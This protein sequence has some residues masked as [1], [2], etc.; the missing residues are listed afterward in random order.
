MAPRRL[1]V[2]G[3]ESFTA[4]AENLRETRCGP[5]AACR[6]STAPTAFRSSGRRSTGPSAHPP[7]PTGTSMPKP[8][9]TSRN[10]TVRSAAITACS[11]AATIPAFAIVLAPMAHNGSSHENGSVEAHNNHLKV[12][13]DQALILRGSR[14]FADLGEWRRFVDE[15]VARRNR[16]REDAVRIEIAALRPLPARR[17]VEPKV[18]LRRNRLHR[19]RR[20]GHE[21][22]G[23]AGPPSLLLRTLA[24]DRQAPSDRRSASGKSDLRSASGETGACL[25]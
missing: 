22:R 3:G 16:R 15:L 1:T 12:A 21:D 9:M 19:G 20:A 7:H 25:R 17:T 24:A 13:R 14:D 6:M 8:P 5:S 2:P 18:R 23:L 4:L 11:R 10:D